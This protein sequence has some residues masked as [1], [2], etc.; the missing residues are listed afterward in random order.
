MKKFNSTF[1]SIEDIVR[2]VNRAAQCEYEIDVKYNNIIVDGKSIVGV[3]SLGI[4]KEVEII[5]HT[6]TVTIEDLI[7]NYKVA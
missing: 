6:E 5:C 7:P 3:A 4:N 1:Y 2:F